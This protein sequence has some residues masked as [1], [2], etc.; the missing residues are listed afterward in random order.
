LQGGIREHLPCVH[1]KLLWT[2][3]VRPNGAVD[4]GHVKQ[5]EI[6]LR[7]V[8]K[9]YRNL[10]VLTEARGL[11][12]RCGTSGLAMRTGMMPVHLAVAVN[13]VALLDGF[14]T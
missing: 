8:L 1:L 5:A 13:A 7:D 9:M 14:L 12:C 3:Q 11:D 4:D 6:T 10:S 2:V